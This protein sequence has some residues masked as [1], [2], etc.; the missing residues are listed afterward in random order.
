MNTLKY[1]FIIIPMFIAKD[2][3]IF[4]SKAVEKRMV[5]VAENLYV[6]QFETTNFEYKEFLKW[7]KT[8]K[9]E[10]TLR[11]SAIKHDGWNDLFGEKYALSYSSNSGYDQYPVVNITYEGARNFCD[12][13]T[14]QYNKDSKRKFRKVKFRL[15][16]AQEW[17]AMANSG[18]EISAYPWG[19]PYLKNS[20]GKFLANFFKVNESNLKIKIDDR[21]SVEINDIDGRLPFTLPLQV[22]TFS[23]GPHGLRNL[24]GNAAEML[25]EK[26]ATKGGSWGSSGYYLRIDAEDEFKDF[27]YSPYVGFRYVMEVIED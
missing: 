17:T 15:P 1:L 25:A 10:K 18:S 5:Q 11:E 27:N 23:Q 16:T 6:N 24:S 12:W 3:D 20:K 8:A 19:S 14:D 2:K 21:N 9:E 26:G 13:L 4:S 22:E 7:T